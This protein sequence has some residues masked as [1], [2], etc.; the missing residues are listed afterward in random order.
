[1][2]LRELKALR[3]SVPK[4]ARV[5]YVLGE[6]PHLTRSCAST[7]PD[8]QVD[9]GFTSRD[10]VGQMQGLVGTSLRAKGWWYYSK[11]GP[12]K[13]YDQI[14]GRQQLANNYIFRWQ[15]KIP[16]KRTVLAT[17]QVGVPTTGWAPG[18]PLSWDIG[19]AAR[20]IDEPAMHCGSG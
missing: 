14:N 5:T 11:S 19:S 2:I 9:I 4:T 17:L 18:A 3:L 1:V 10:A 20:G 15:R 13:W 6:E 7:T 16:Q 12:L 8:V